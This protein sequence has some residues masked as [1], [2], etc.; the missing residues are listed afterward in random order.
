MSS[1]TPT[2]Y[3]LQA[4]ILSARAMSTDGATHDVLRASYEKVVS[5]GL[6]R[7]R[8]LEAGQDLLARARLVVVDH[9]RCIP[10]AELLR[11]R[12]LP[13]DVAAEL[14]LQEV[15]AADPPLWLSA[16]VAAEDVRWEN[17]PDDD[18]QALMQLISDADRREAILLAL[19]R[20]VDQRRLKELG[21][22]GEE[23][24]ATACRKHLADRGRS[25]LGAYVE[26]VSLRSDQLGYDVTSPDTSGRR[27]RI[28]VK[29][30]Q[31]LRGDVEFYLSR[32][33]ATVGRRDPM[34]SLVAVRKALTGEF[35]IFGWCRARGFTACL[36]ADGPRGRWESVRVSLPDEMFRPGLPLDVDQ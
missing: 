9:Q 25:D 21:G 11:M 28:E 12:E 10:I 6:F 14:L 26:R 27:H 20:V 31:G 8:D 23:T 29:T 7:T 24:V 19:G 22:V 33:E 30:T 17:V 18:A 34:W 36:P 4:A 32:N 13:D 16:A 35:E 1:N 5:G 15:L 3:Q 2:A